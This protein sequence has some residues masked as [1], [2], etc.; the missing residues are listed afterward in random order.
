MDSSQS[1]LP[2]SPLFGA[3]TCLPPPNSYVHQGA[4]QD[5][6]NQISQVRVGLDKIQSLVF[7]VWESTRVFKKV[8]ATFPSL[9]FAS[10][11]LEPVARRQ[12]SSPEG[13]EL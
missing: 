6:G 9:L 5:T 11:V 4:G 10:P 3:P 1:V 13:L 8:Q 7:L 2:S 12:S